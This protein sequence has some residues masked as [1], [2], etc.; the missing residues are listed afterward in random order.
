MLLW[1]VNS[2]KELNTILI[3]PAPMTHL[4]S[5]P[6]ISKV[7][8]ALTA[9]SDHRY[10]QLSDTQLKVLSS[11]RRKSYLVTY[12]PSTRQIYSNDNTAYYTHTISYPMILFLLL[13]GELSYDPTLP[14]LLKG[15]HWKALNTRF[16]N[17]YDQALAHVLTTLASQG[18]DLP[19]FQT[20]LNSLY[21]QVLA[22][23]LAPLP[24]RSRPPQGY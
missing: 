12:N 22:L 14:P 3:A 17:N 20:K 8:E 18:V 13:R 19:S 2:T 1:V 10:E 7:Y 21:Q 15:I 5:S 11:S 16:K 24:S 6:H 9:L 23:K 4:Y